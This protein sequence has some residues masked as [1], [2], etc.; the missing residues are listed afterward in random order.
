M[1][2]LIGDGA[3]EQVDDLGVERAVLAFGELDQLAVQVGVE[4][5][6]ETN[7]LSHNPRICQ[8]GRHLS[9]LHDAG[10]HSTGLHGVRTSGRIDAIDRGCE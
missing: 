7:K 9:C 8:N 5:D 6:D 1:L 2:G 3:L 4:A 10:G